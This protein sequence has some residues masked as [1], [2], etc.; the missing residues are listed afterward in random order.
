MNDV[1]KTI[2]SRKGTRV[3]KKTPI[4]KETLELLAKAAVAGPECL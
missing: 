1:I 2:L 4:S 3:Y